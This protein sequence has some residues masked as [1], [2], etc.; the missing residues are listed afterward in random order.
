MTWDE[1]V[2]FLGDDFTVAQFFVVIWL[3]YYA[4][5]DPIE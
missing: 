3:V 5:D 1:I 4:G 2:A